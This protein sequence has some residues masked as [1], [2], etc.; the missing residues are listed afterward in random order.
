M[1][2]AEWIEAEGISR[3]AAG[4][5]LAISRSYMTELCQRK[6]TPSVTIA[7][8]INEESGA[9]VTFRDMMANGHEASE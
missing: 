3:A 6:R 1:T 2:L 7:I 9:R 8:R 4:R 5:R